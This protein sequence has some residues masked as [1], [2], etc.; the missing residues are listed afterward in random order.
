MTARSTWLGVIINSRRLRRAVPDQFSDLDDVT[1]G[2][3]HS[4]NRRVPGAVKTFER[5]AQLDEYL[6]K[7]RW[8]FAPLPRYV[9]GPLLWET[10]RIVRP[11][12]RSEHRS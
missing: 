11:R 6:L 10:V 1:A 7:C 5:D 3:S 9:T 8:K 12:D 4:S 2:E